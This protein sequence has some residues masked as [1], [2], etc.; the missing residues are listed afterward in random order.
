LLIKAVFC[1]EPIR[2]KTMSSLLLKFEQWALGVSEL[3]FWLQVVDVRL[4]VTWGRGRDVD[5]LLMHKLHVCELLMYFVHVWCWIWP[6]LHWASSYM[7]AS[8][9]MFYAHI[10]QCPCMYG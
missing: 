4:L 1:F 9:S 5:G 10:N 3:S 8:M 7:N 6:T 2:Y